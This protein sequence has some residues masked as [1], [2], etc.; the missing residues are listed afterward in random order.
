MKKD[1]ELLADRLGVAADDSSTAHT[2]TLGKSFNITVNASSTLAAGVGAHVK[3][4]VDGKAIGT[5]TIKATAA[6]YTFASKLMPNAPHTVKVVYSN[7][8]VVGGHDRN[9]SLNG[10]RTNGHSIS[11]S[12]SY[13]TYQ[14]KGQGTF[15]SDGAMNWNGTATFK[16]PASI[17]R[18]SGSHT[19]A[20][21]LYVSTGGNDSGSGVA[22]SPFATLAKAVAAAEQS[23][24]HVIKIEGGTYRISST[25]NLGSANSGLTIESNPGSHAVLDGSGTQST[26]INLSGASN[27][28]LRHLTFQN[29]GS[30]G[31]AVVLSGA[32]HNRIV[33]NHF[34]NT[35]EGLLLQNGSSN[36]VVSGNELDNSATS[37]IEVQNASN[38]NRF[39]SNLINGTGA[40]GTQGGGIFMHGA[41]N[42]VISHNLV[43]NTAGIGIGIENWDSNT[44]NVGN[45]VLDNILKN[46]SMSTAS[47]DSGAIYMLGRSDVNT[48]SVIRGNYISAPNAPQNAHVVGIYLDELTSGVNISNNIVTN[49]ITH[50]VQIHGGSNVSV[51]NNIFDLGANSGLQYGKD[52]AILFQSENGQA[53]TGNSFAQNIIASTSPTP[54]GLSSI[55][56]GNPT[57][58]DNFY[59]DLLNSHFG[60]TG[61]HLNETNAHFGNADFVN[62]AAGNYT[63]GS[64]SGAHAIGFVSINQS[65]MGLHPTT[66]HWYS[67]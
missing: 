8:A 43:E 57:I 2:S 51:H 37:A 20:P 65:V 46:T 33:G 21:A 47:T 27:V 29:T 49:V 26:L 12:S 31:A 34:S 50:A 64:G 7:D 23:G 16:L 56:G 52:S 5:A 54:L 25:L 4:L 28:I 24:I 62:Q 13:E 41:N 39:D 6:D 60:T 35:H 42:N 67:V 30:N 59:M 38:G 19:P 14:A 22:S 48:Q 66:V 40:I 11:A 17:F 3:V 53:M 45:S 15:K 10:I 61:D 36:N 63:L 55:G 1:F 9:L 58:N 44:I 32:D 18:V